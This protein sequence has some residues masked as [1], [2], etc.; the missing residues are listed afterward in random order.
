MGVGIWVAQSSHNTISHN[1]IHDLFYSGMSIGWNWDDAPNRCHHNTIEWNHVHHVMKGMLSDGGAIYTLG[2]APGS[3][4][5]NNVFHDVWPYPNP[6]FGWGIYLDATS[7]GYLVE[8]N[9]V[10]NVLSGCLMYANGGHEHVIRNNVFAFPANYM[11]WPFWEKRSNTFQRNLMLM[12]QGTLFV[13][14][15]EASFQQ[16][17]R[18]RSRS[19]R[20]MKISIGTAASG[21]NW[22]CSSSISRVAGPRAGPQFVD[23]RPKIRE[24][25]RA[26]LPTPAGFAGLEARFSAD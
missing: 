7:S 11:L 26:Q 10:Y 21:T 15:A 19:A 17:L 13:P 4:I 23:R 20:G 1:E 6:P 16:R 12:S 24:R 2:A 22:R 3:I 18:A 9:V 5:R 14:L 25:G 8:N